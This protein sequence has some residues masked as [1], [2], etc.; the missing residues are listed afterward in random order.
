MSESWVEVI[1]GIARDFPWIRWLGIFTIIV[2]FVLFLIVAF[3]VIRGDWIPF[4]F[5]ASGEAGND[6]SRG[7]DPF[8]TE[9]GGVN[10][11][12]LHEAASGMEPITRYMGEKDR[13]INTLK[14]ILSELKQDQKAEADRQTDF[15][16]MMEIVADGVSSALTHAYIELENDFSIDYPYVIDSIQ[17]AMANERVKNPGVAVFVPHASHQFLVP[18]SWVGL[19]QSF[20]DYRLP[21]TARSPEGWVWLHACTRGWNHLPSREFHPIPPATRSMIA[22]PLAVDDK[23]VGVL[24]VY[25]EVEEGFWH[26]M[27]NRHLATFAKLLSSLVYLDRYSTRV[28]KGGRER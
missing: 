6:W 27:D 18:A 19:A 2:L 1:A 4:W 23:K 22:S 8:P 17:S 26:P 24:A 20:E 12:P 25:S 14:E 21:L 5:H 28:P 7:T 9:P 16:A 10:R 13:Q 11:S 3:R 15:I